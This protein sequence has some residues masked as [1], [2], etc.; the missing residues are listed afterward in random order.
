MGYLLKVGSSISAIDNSPPWVGA[1]VIEQAIEDDRKRKEEEEREARL[2]AAREEMGLPG[3]GFT[4]VGG[5]AAGLAAAA[6]YKKLFREL[7]DSP[8][9]A[10]LASPDAIDR[11]A[12][13]ALLDK[14]HNEDIA[15]I[16]ENEDLLPAATGVDNPILEEAYKKLPEIDKARLLNRAGFFSP[17]STGRIL[18]DGKPGIW[19]GLT[20][21][22]QAGVLAHEYGHALNTAERGDTWRAVHS[23]LYG[24]G[25]AIPTAATAGLTAAGLLGASDNTLLAGGILGSLASAPTLIEEIRASARGKKILDEAGIVPKDGVSTFAGVPSYLGLAVLPLLPY[26]G[27]KAYRGIKGLFIGK[28]NKQKQDKDGRESA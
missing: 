28:E 13:N 26:L 1:S 4:S 23:K 5:A 15:R 6:G 22:I 12:T 8:V 3:F 24:L 25:Q 10:A 2:A 17:F 7:Y 19:K 14:I 20:G 11:Q 9:N 18:D 27:R 16:L 21:D